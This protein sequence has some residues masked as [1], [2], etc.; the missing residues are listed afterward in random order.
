MKKSGYPHDQGD[1]RNSTHKTFLQVKLFNKRHGNRKY[2]EI[3]AG[4]HIIIYE[5]EKGLYLEAV[6]QTLSVYIC[7]DSQD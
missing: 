1:V 6:V 4:Y 3:I 5:I 2:S 7:H